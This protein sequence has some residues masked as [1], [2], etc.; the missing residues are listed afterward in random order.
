[1]DYHSFSLVTT[2][3]KNPLIQKTL[4]S[5][6]PEPL[7]LLC[8]NLTSER[9]FFEYEY[10]ELF[11]NELIERVTS[12]DNKINQLRQEMTRI[13]ETIEILQKEKEWAAKMVRFF[14]ESG[15]KYNG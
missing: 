9:E 2:E 13:E 7:D 3:H 1:M 11:R 4:E 5:D 15:G 12:L 6:F 10:A 8:D 14:K